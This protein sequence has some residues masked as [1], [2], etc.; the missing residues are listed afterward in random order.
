MKKYLVLLV[1]IFI[2]VNICNSQKRHSHQSS[3]KK[4]N[5]EKPFVIGLSNKCVEGLLNSCSDNCMNGNQTLNAFALYKFNLKW[6]APVS[7][8]AQSFQDAKYNQWMLDKIFIL[9]YNSDRGWMNNNFSQ[10]GVR[11]EYCNQLSEFILSHIDEIKFRNEQHDNPQSSIQ[12]EI[13]STNQNTN[14]LDIKNEIKFKPFDDIEIVQ[15]N[16]DYSID[17]KTNL[18]D[19]RKNEEFEAVEQMAEYR[20]GIDSLFAFIQKNLRY[21]KNAWDNGIQGKVILRFVVS[22]T[23]K[24]ATVIV[25]N[26]QIDPELANEAIRV[27]RMMPDWIP[28]QHK[29]ENVSV[30][31]TLPITFKLP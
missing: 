26:R 1:V 13:E 7:Y 24:I 23:G 30:W 19:K 8:A 22:K 31:V 25:E 29:E 4:I 15:I 3:V 28:A 14:K 2:S 27:V 18:T 11:Y 17:K 16:D 6:G 21:P 20:G 10:L 12:Q 5:T 9:F